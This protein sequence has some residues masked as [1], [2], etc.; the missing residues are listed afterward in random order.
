LHVAPLVLITLLL[1]APYMYKM[2]TGRILVM[3][4]VDSALLLLCSVGISAGINAHTMLSHFLLDPCFYYSLVLVCV[5]AK[6]SGAPVRT[7]W[8]GVTVSEG[9]RISH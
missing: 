7:Q 6:L 5:A 2:V 4:F 9:R 3:R 8:K 1:I